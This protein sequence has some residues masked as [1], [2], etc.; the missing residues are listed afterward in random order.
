ME[1]IK[2]AFDDA[3]WLY[4]LLAIHTAECSYEP[5]REIARELRESIKQQVPK[6]RLW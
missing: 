6:V 2:L 4:N 1:N 5:D 3:E